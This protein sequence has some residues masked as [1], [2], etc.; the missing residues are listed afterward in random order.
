[1]KA[2]YID[3]EGSTVEEALMKYLNERSLDISE[4]RYKVLQLPSGGSPARVRIFLD[5]E[6]FDV[7][8]EVAREFLHRLGVK[9]GVD[10]DVDENGRYY[11]NFDIKELDNTLIGHQGQ[12]LRAINH[13]LSSIIKKRKPH[14]KVH[15][16]IA[17]YRRRRVRRAINK[18]IAILKLMETQGKTE[19]AYDAPIQSDEVEAVR[20]FLNTKGYTMERLKVKGR[21]IKSKT[22]EPV[23]IIRK[24]T[25]EELQKLKDRESKGS[26]SSNLQ[27]NTER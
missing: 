26:T 19:M 8:D 16:D 18:A 3:L 22:G 12:T 14:I 21:R 5:T 25:E 24:L 27:S 10:I 2:R 9:G 1:M 15:F 20:R 17:H 11:V 6:D 13:L 23:Y 4:I 7:I